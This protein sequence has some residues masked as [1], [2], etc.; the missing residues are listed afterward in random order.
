MKTTLVMND[1]LGVY[2]INMKPTV[3]CMGM[4]EKAGRKTKQKHEES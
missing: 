1:S 2:I 4:F 3:M